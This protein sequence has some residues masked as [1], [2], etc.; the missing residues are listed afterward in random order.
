[1]FVATIAVAV[2]LLGRVDEGLGSRT[3]F[4]LFERNASLPKDISFL[5]EG[6][7]DD[8][9]LDP[10]ADEGDSK[11]QGFYA[12]RSD[13]ASLLDLYFLNSDDQPD[14]RIVY[15]VIDF[16]LS[17]LDA[18]PDRLP[19][20]RARDLFCV[21]RKW[22]DAPPELYYN[23]AGVSPCESLGRTIRLLRRWPF[24]GAI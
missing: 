20:L 22:R 7:I 5:Y 18:T 21:S 16:N 24:F 12:Y 9:A 15:G 17:I 8:Q 6:R 14:S 13:G 3:C 10:D 4:A 1:M 19:R 11:F 2:A 23:S